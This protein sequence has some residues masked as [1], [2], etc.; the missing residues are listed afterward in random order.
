[1]PLPIFRGL[2]IIFATSL[3]ACFSY[4]L[5]QQ[6][7]EAEIAA[8]FI[9]GNCYRSIDDISR[10]KS[11][12][13]IFKWQPL[14]P[15]LASAMKP[16]ESGGYES[17]HVLH[18]GQHFFVGVNTGNERG[19]PVEVCTVIANHPPEVL[20]PIVLENVKTRRFV[21]RNTNG[22]QTTATYELE[23]PTQKLELAMLSV[24]TGVNNDPPVNF[25]FIGFR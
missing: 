7:T 19:K 11:M 24:T 10:V 8:E 22:L 18:Q 20:V 2:Q 23:H 21:S 12:A 25:S 4:A 9:I 3:T 1:M 17:W 16:V 14:P 6:K 13:R 5:A 15:D